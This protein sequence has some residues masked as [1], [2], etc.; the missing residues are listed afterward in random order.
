MLKYFCLSKGALE[1]VVKAFL[2]QNF[3]RIEDS[4]SVSWRALKVPFMAYFSQRHC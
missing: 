3:P 2:L 4:A 1:G